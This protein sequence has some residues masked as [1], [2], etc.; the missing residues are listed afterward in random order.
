M[1]LAVWA[2][3]Y[4]PQKLN[5]VINQKHVVER[6]KAFVKEKNIP[7]M[8]FAGPAGTGKTTIALCMARELYGKEWRR[9]VLELNASVTP[10]TPILIRKNG[11]ISRTTIGDLASEY[12]KDEKSKYAYPKDLE[13]LS[14]DK[15]LK[16]R[17]MPVKN[18]SRH[19][20]DKIA[21]IRFEG[22]EVKTTL[23]HSVIIMD[24]DG[25]LSEVKVSELKKGDLLISF[26]T[27]IRGNENQ[28]DFSRFK[29]KEFIRLKKRTI[30]NP[31]VKK[32]IEKVKVNEDIAWLLGSF[33]AEGCVGFS[34]TSGVV[35]FTY[36]YPKE[37]DLANKTSS[38]IAKH[39]GFN[40]S[41]HTIFSGSSGRESG[42]Q[43]TVSSTQLARFLKE[44]FYEGEARAEF[45]KVPKFVFNW[46]LELRLAFL[47]GY[48]GDAYGSWEKYVRYSSK[49]QEL[50]K[51]ITWLGRI[52]GLDTSW[53]RRE[54]RLLWKNKMYSREELV[55]AKPLIKFFQQ[56][57]GKVGFNWRYMLR[58]Q[59][60]HKKSKRI[61][62]NHY[63]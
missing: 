33:L 30:R 22:G 46:P 25:R 3:K 42:V 28:L 55:P 17:F 15:D 54:S 19:K 7:H 59:L 48:M 37:M 38:I 45:K 61:K 40:S 56:I 60:Y 24:E 44:M 16:I 43:V 49:S 18:I 57:D 23:D 9:N 6:V 35:V 36:G 32:I 12:F 50:L 53:F 63:S 4:R 2:E 20:V 27:K 21:R 29:P 47:K 11:E 51:D 62:K 58:H 10:D 52:S 31:T 39:F 8:L 26:K 1:E 41:I 13:V 34:S 14:V 5:E